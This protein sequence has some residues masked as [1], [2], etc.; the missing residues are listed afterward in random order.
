V[1]A[2]YLSVDSAVRGVGRSQVLPVVNGLAARGWEM[3]LV[4]CER[5]V[6]DAVAK[7]SQYLHSSVDYAPVEFG[8]AGPIGAAGRIVRLRSAVGEPNLI[9]CRSDQPMV[10]AITRRPR[11]RLVWDS[12]SFWAEQRWRLE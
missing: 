12:R 5:S 11:C 10:A 4:S 7:A 3:R 2:T 1:K 9:H 8:G 6:S